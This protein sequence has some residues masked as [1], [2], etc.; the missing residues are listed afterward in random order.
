MHLKRNTGWVSVLII[1][2]VCIIGAVFILRRA[3][4]IKLER[5]SGLESEKSILE[6]THWVEEKVPIYY[7]QKDKLW[8]VNSDGSNKVCLSKHKVS[9]YK[10]SPKNQHMLFIEYEL[11]K[12]MRSISILD[13]NDHTKEPVVIDR[14][15]MDDRKSSYRRHRS[16]EWA[17]DG[18]RFVFFVD[19]G[20][21]FEIYLY[22]L[23][24]Q[25]KSLLLDNSTLSSFGISGFL[26]IVDDKVKICWDKSG[27]YI[28]FVGSRNKFFGFNVKNLKLKLL[29]EVSFSNQDLIPYG[30]EFKKRVSIFE[31]LG[32]HLFYNNGY[33]P[34]T[35][36]KP[37]DKIESVNRK[38]S[39]SSKGD[40]IFTK[41]SPSHRLKDLYFRDIDGNEVKIASF[42]TDY[43]YMKGVGDRVSALSWLPGDRYAL[44][45]LTL[46]RFD[47]TRRLIIIEP[48]TG[49]MGL[50]EDDVYTFNF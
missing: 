26:G 31:S 48:A 40:I 25:E 2:L 17:P 49:K 9:S 24:S 45:L 14:F 18:E 10:I 33:P 20:E 43:H 11:N 6:D 32:A 23:T 35:R 15:A 50:L 13:L 28:Y 19:D 21:Q 5:K 7:L 46:N 8:S 44:M 41:L 30:K 22:D 16:V 1:V 34:N 39:A 42:W 12:E 29:K 36:M 38:G 47:H 4:S 37:V 27:E 3:I